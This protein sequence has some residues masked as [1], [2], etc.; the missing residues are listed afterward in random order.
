AHFIGR[1]DPS[2][3]AQ[4]RE[5]AFAMP[6][7]AGKTQFRALELSDGGAALVALSAV[8]VAAGHDAQGQ[9]DRALQEAQRLGTDTVVAYIEEVRR[10]ADVRKNPKAFD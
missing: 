2:I 1:R 7:P 9:T 3:P 8:R 4:V 5:A 6:K 10:T